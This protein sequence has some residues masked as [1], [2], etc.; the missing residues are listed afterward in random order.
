MKHRTATMSPYR[1]WARK[2]IDQVIS[3]NVHGP[4]GCLKNEDLRVLKKILYTAVCFGGL[5]VWEKR[6]LRDEWRVTLGYPARSKPKM[7]RLSGRDDCMPA[8]RD[9]ALKHGLIRAP[10]TTSGVEVRS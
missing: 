7:K 3:D 1:V 2:V 6:I 10:E 8:M 4:V 9:W 5:S